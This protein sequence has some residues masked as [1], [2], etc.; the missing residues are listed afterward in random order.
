MTDVTVDAYLMRMLILSRGGVGITP[1]RAAAARFL[2]NHDVLRLPVVQ[3]TL[4]LA[5]RGFYHQRRGRRRERS[6]LEPRARVAKY[7]AMGND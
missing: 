6:P 7:L 4:I 5:T 1:T 2:G 3:H